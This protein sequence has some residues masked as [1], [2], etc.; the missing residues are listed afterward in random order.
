MKTENL[1]PPELS[2]SCPRPHSA[3]MATTSSQ[4][5]VTRLLATLLAL[6]VAP[7]AARDC[8]TDDAN[9]E[10]QTCTAAA[11]YCMLAAGWPPAE[12]ST[13]VGCRGRSSN[14]CQVADIPECDFYPGSDVCTQTGVARCRALG[15][16]SHADACAAHIG[17]IC[18]S[19]W[20]CTTPAP[21]PLAS[22][23]LDPLTVAL[24]ALVS[25]FGVVIIGGGAYMYTR[26]V[27]RVKRAVP[28][29][30]ALSTPPSAA[31][32]QVRPQ[33]GR[34]DSKVRPPDAQAKLGLAARTQE[35]DP[36][37]GVGRW[38]A[39][40]SCPSLSGTCV[41]M[42]ETV[43]GLRVCACACACACVA[44]LAVPAADVDATREWREESAAVQRA[45]PRATRG[46]GW[47]PRVWT[48]ARCMATTASRHA[49]VLASA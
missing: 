45:R 9:C 29:E 36:R 25:V 42:S 16:M 2:P 48:A 41:M 32:S 47:P 6:L 38:R 37:A 21:A 35:L 22:D 19:T 30:V 24:I 17:L 33:H 10:G 28:T 39:A 4:R 44:V 8:G 13:Y 11:P 15:G 26:R 1:H 3:T 5:I 18:A 14:S 7:G 20:T 31:I 12:A 46:C 23:S 27:T 43:L 34:A 49:T 40:A